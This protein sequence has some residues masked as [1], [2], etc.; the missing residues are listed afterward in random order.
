MNSLSTPSGSRVDLHCHS[1][2]SNGA[3]GKPPDIARVLKQAG[4][5]AFALTEHDTFASQAAAA[6]GARAAGI[7]FV[8]GIEISTRVDDDRLRGQAYPHVLGY[9]FERTPELDAM[10]NRAWQGSVDRLRAGV[11]R[12]RAEGIVDFG[13]PELRAHI[14]AAWGADDVW[15]QPFNCSMPLGQM[16]QARGLGLPDE[17]NNACRTASRVLGQRYPPPEAAVWPGVQEVCDTLHRAGAVVILAHPTSLEGD[18]VRRWLDGYVDGIEVYHPRNRPEYRA[19][20]LEIVRS[21]GCAFTGGSDLHWYGMANLS[22]HLSDA[23]YEC[24]ESLRAAKSVRLSL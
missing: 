12:L 8:P 7:E 22:D 24:L 19:M 9:F 2:A 3:T 4:F 10:V 21:T 20:L 5:A 15:K 23:P 13:E 16:L 11:D 6:E 1:S 17:H 18:V 14:R